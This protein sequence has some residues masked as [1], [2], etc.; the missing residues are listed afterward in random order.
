MIESALIDPAPP[1]ARGW[2]WR[3]AAPI[4]PTRAAAPIRS[5]GP[6]AIRSARPAIRSARP[7]IRSARPAIRSFRTLALTESAG[8]SWL[9]GGD[10]GTERP[11]G[12]GG[13]NC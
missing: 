13:R 2:P 9:G 6:A 10:G 4:R 1:Q 7:A 12:Q 11:G 3:P 5:A 8:W